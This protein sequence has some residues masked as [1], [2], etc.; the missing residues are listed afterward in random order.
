MYVPAHGSCGVEL[1]RYGYHYVSA[2]V[3][4][5]APAPARGHD[6]DCGRDDE[7]DHCHFVHGDEDET[8]RKR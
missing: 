4:D 8:T 7:N 6:H 1:G 5:R 2:N 3:H